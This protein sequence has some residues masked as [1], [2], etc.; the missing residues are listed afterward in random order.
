M[1]KMKLWVALLLPSMAMADVRITAPGEYDDG[2]SL[3]SSDISHYHV[4]VVDP[5]SLV[6]DAE[7]D[8]VGDTIDATVLPADAKAVKARTVLNDG[9]VSD[10]WSNTV[11]VNLPDPLPPELSVIITTTTTIEVVQ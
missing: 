4:C 8:I 1:R 7:F 2:S 5:V 9:R 10:D 11:Y 6:C 3:S